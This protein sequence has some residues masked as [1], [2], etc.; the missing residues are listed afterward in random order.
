MV[1]SARRLYK[2]ILIANRESANRRLI[3]LL[4]AA[5]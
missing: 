3:D 4:P 1:G 5:L 2:D